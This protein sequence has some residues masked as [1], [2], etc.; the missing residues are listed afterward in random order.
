MT[1]CSVIGRE[2]NFLWPSRCSETYPNEKCI[3]FEN[4]I[5]MFNGNTSYYSSQKIGRV[6]SLLQYVQHKAWLIIMII[7]K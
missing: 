2:S 6:E 7:E 3:V 1:K 4:K 5:G